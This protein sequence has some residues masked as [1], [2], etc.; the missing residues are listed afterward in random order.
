MTLNGHQREITSL[1][2]SADGRL[3]ISG[4]GDKTARI[5]DMS[6]GSSKVLTV[7][8][9]DHS[10]IV[11]SV[12]LSPDGQF[13]AAG[14][15]YHGVHVWDVSTGSMVE[16][17]R[18]YNNLMASIAFTSDGKGLVSGGVERTSL[19]DS[20]GTLSYCDLTGLKS[21]RNEDGTGTH[22]VRSSRA[23]GL[24]YV[25]EEGRQGGQRRV[26]YTG[27]TVQ[28]QSSLPL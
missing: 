26:K 7:N 17:L 25:T 9:P 22:P 19:H 5:W 28:Y 4:S 6:N 15:D 12:A 21:I 24:R 2:F 14:S 20:A 10:D 3:V 13:V 23:A 16:H 27:H 1:D 11:Q 18:D 8:N